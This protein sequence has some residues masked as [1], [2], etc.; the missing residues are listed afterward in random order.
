MVTPAPTTAKQAVIRKAPNP[1]PNYSKNQDMVMGTSIT[2]RM[3]RRVRRKMERMV[4][5]K[6]QRRPNYSK[7]QDMV[8]VTAT[9]AATHARLSPKTRSR[10]C[11][12]A[13]ASCATN[14]WIR[15][16]T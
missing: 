11:V 5:R 2:E 3:E 14:E 15:L 1:N 16:K 6:H 12:V 10:R 7:N 9:R 8:M 13:K 4:R